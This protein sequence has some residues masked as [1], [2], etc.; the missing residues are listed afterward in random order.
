MISGVELLSKGVLDDTDND[1]KTLNLGG[2]NES[3]GVKDNE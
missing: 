3:M 2:I 1:E